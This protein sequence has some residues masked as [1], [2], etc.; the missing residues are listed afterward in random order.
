MSESTN[1]LPTDIEEAHRMIKEL[2]TENADR[3][4]KAK[5]F[6]DAFGDYSPEEQTV[7]LGIVRTLASDQVEGGIALRNLAVQVLGEDK[8]KDGLDFL[9]PVTPK[10]DPEAGEKE[11]ETVSAG[12]SADELKAELDR[13][14]A[15]RAAAASKADEEAA[16]AGIFKEIEDLGFEQGS[17]G[18]LTLLSLANT[19]ASL[20][21]DP[22]FQALAPQVRQL[23][24]LPEPEAVTE[25]EGEA[26]GLT[27]AVETSFPSTAGAGGAG[28]AAEP[29]KDWIAEAKAAGK[30]PMEAARER[31]ERRMSGV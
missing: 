11:E 2:R 21:K 19:Q 10:E 13:R 26:E 15:D 28:A 7:L 24:G 14:D 3:R 23:V 30:S 27:T 4:V 6:T 29:Q 22:D 17:E 9:A 16:I 31:A 18:F 20:G 25:G 12:L 5:P 8:F 1:A